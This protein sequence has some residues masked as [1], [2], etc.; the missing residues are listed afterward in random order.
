MASIA[1]TQQTDRRRK[2]ALLRIREAGKA[3]YRL[4]GEEPDWWRPII[5][6][7]HDD[8][9][10]GARMVINVTHVYLTDKGEAAIRRR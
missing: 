5:K 10:I 7:L 4:T 6:S 3:G 1:E 2:W 9:L 8:R